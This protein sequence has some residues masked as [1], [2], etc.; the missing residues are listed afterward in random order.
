MSEIK[1]D[2]VTAVKDF[3]SW[4]DAV[5]I[6][7]DESSMSSED[8]KGFVDL[9]NRI[10]KA[11]Q[12][13]SCVVDGDKIEYTL[14]NRYEGQMAGMKIIVG[15]PTGRVFLG[16]DGYKDTQ[17]IHKLHGAMSALTGFDVGF[18]AKMNIKDWKFFQSVL[19]L[20]LAV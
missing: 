15:M 14:G 18:F 1:I 13:G 20:F 7:Y 11:I 6:D 4:C 19:T 17:A 5:G 16:M 9:K 10:V 12:E 3:E 2:N 8:Q